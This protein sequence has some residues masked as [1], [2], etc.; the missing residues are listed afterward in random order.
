MALLAFVVFCTMARAL[1][2]R[3]AYLVGMLFAVAL[4]CWFGWGEGAA[5]VL[6]IGTYI[7]VSAVVTF[8]FMC[9]YRNYRDVVFRR[10]G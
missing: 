3:R 6:L 9:G 10:Y 4:S 8:V 1:G 7:C 2:E 5:S